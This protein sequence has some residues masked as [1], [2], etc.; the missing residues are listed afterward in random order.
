MRP[1][2]EKRQGTKSR[3]VRHPAV[4]RARYADLAAERDLIAFRMSSGFYSDHNLGV[5]WREPCYRRITVSAPPI[6]RDRSSPSATLD[7]R[8][9]IEVKGARC[10]P[11]CDM[12]EGVAIASEAEPPGEGCMADERTSL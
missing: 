2:S 12:A 5:V 6:H 10:D 8:T 11:N 4:Q 9:F 3:G 7:G 1:A